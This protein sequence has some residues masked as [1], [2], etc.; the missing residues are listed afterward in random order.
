MVCNTHAA[1]IA[2]FHGPALSS[3]GGY[4]RKGIH[5]EQKSNQKGT[6]LCDFDILSKRTIHG[7]LLPFMLKILSKKLN[8]ASMFCF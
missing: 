1:F 3:T 4:E 2:V 5:S 8:L 7:F 6:G